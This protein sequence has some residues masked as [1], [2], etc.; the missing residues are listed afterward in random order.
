MDS[1]REP[2]I[3]I[4]HKGV[5]FT[6]TDLTGGGSSIAPRGSFI[7]IYVSTVADGNKLYS[8]NMIAPRLVTGND[9]PVPPAPN[10]SQ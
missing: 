9:P 10:S 4:Y 7:C 6:I 5:L 2:R 8:R 1:T 3:K